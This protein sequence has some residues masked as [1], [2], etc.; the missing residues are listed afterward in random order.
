[1]WNGLKI[2]SSYSDYIS[3]NMFSLQKYDI[4][5]IT[6]IIIVII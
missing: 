1:M 3:D 2:I 4:N 5:I 6:I